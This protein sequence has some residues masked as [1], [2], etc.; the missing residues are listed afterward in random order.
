MNTQQVL[1]RA[2]RDSYRRIGK[3]A[4]VLLALSGGADS[5]ALLH[6]LSVLKKQ[7]GFSLFCIHINHGL[8]EASVQ[9][10]GF[11]QSLAHAYEVPLQIRRIEVIREGNLEEAARTARYQVFDETLFSSRANVLALAHH[12]GD[13]AETVL[14]HL[15]RGAGLD[16]VSGMAEFRPPYWRPLLLCSQSM[17]QNYLK[18]LDIPFVLDESNLDTRFLRNDL[19]RNV[20]NQLEE[21]A[22]GAIFRIAQ[23][24][25]VLHDENLL[26]KKLE[27]AWLSKFA[28]LEPPFLYLLTK[29]FLNEETALQ[30]RLLRRLTGVFEIG[31][32]FKQ[33]ERLRMQLLQESPGSFNLPGNATAVLTPERLHIL[34][35]DVKLAKHFWPQPLMEPAGTGM[36]DGKREQVVDADKIQGAVMRQAGSDD[37]I[38]PLGTNGTQTLRKYL[39]ARKVDPPFRPY[40]PVFARGSQVLWVPGYGVSAAVAVTPNTTTRMRLVFQGTLP[41]EITQ[42]GGEEP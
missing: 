34:H 12:A 16:G 18:E 10:E 31:L 20:F 41:H 3:P 33:T 19:R 32:D 26:L 39:S 6:L 42:V 21:K 38:S 2:V 22:P 28:R 40:W 25:Q 13:Q 36:G 9:E 14:M 24:A 27:E 4:S 29:P 37:T 7:E 17:L 23:T 11:V 1:L 8:R 15:M 35:D 5:V 30:R